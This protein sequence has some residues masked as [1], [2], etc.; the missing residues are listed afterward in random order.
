MILF[1]RKAL[2]GRL[3]FLSLEMSGFRVPYPTCILGLCASAI[4]VPAA[5]VAAGLS[6]AAAVLSHREASC[7]RGSQAVATEPG[8]VRRSAGDGPVGRICQD[9]C[10]EGIGS[11]WGLH[12]G[13]ELN[14]GLFKDADFI[15]FLHFVLK[16]PGFLCILA[17]LVSHSF[18]RRCRA[19]R[20]HQWMES[21]RPVCQYPDC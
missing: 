14:D 7:N 12:K 16:N 11:E 4:L 3:C 1:F 21:G 9:S 18:L 13:V 20:V 19:R 17:A 2:R 10:C 8:L 15:T 5:I 6:L